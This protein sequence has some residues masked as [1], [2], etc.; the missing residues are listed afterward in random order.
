M[1]SLWKKI[2]YSLLFLNL[3]FIGAAL[4]L[5]LKPFNLENDVLAEDVTEVSSSEY[6]ITPPLAKIEHIV[7]IGDS[8]T[9]GYQL[10]DHFT[11]LELPPVNLGVNGETSEQVLG[12]LDH[13]LYEL[14]PKKLFLLIGTNDLVKTKKT[15]GE[16][17]TT[18]KEI[19]TTLQEQLPETAIFVE[20]VYPVNTVDFLTPNHKKMVG[21]RNNGTIVKL[22]QLIQ[23]VTLETK[24]TYLEVYPVL[25]DQ[26]AQLIKEYSYDGLHLNQAGYD[27]I[28][29]FLSPYV[30]D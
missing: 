1:T 23:L 10:T 4:F 14:R 17:A 19:I 12:R 22:N 13:T 6:V 24:T 18:I 27:V 9:Y 28:T 30:Y 26:R 8:I 5:L 25:L 7:F 15:P 16:I 3:I 29:E 11:K 2:L 20:S 21:S